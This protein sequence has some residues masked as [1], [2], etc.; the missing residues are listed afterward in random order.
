MTLHT[1]HVAHNVPHQPRLPTFGVAC[2]NEGTESVRALAH[3]LLASRGERR[4]IDRRRRNRLRARAGD[5]SGGPRFTY[6]AVFPLEEIDPHAEIR[7]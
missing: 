2:E 4:R 1:S 7:L 5:K 3:A 6:T